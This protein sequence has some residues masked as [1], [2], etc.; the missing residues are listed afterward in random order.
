MRIRSLALTAALFVTLASPAFV[1]AQAAGSSSV[2]QFWYVSGTSI[3][4]GSQVWTYA[5]TNLT[6]NSTFSDRDG[7]KTQEITEFHVHAVVP[8]KDPFPLANGTNQYPLP[9]VT[10][11]YDTSQVIQ[12]PNQC[13]S[14]NNSVGFVCGVPHVDLQHQVLEIRLVRLLEFSDTNGD[15]GYADGEPILSQVNL[16]H[17]SMQYAIPSVFGLD[18]SAAR[19]NL[20]IRHNSSASYGDSSDGWLGQNEAA[21]GSFDGMGFTLSGSGPVSLAVTGYQWFDSRSFQGT[22]MTPGRVKI[23]LSIGS[24]PFQSLN[25]RLAVELNVTSF[26]QQSSTDWSVLPSTYGEGLGIDASNTTA[27]FAWASTAL[28]DNVSAQVVGT[29]LPVD[30]LSRS[31]YFSYPYAAS[32]QHDPVLGITDKRLTGGQVLGPPGV[33][34]FA[35]AWIAF[36]GALFGTGAVIYF[37]ERRKR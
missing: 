3:I 35:W 17:R 32:I 4:G 28:A 11:Y 15:K 26:S 1:S 16:D 36:G 20:P 23:D 29:V 21:F 6:M 33:A 12:D 19:I 14:A 18:D 30:S 37:V 34:S 2:I 22:N 27:V 5:G 8:G 31:V 13:V 9:Q 7:V 24:Y 25:S 10:V